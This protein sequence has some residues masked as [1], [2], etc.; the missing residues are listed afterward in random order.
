M[1]NIHEYHTLPSIGSINAINLQFYSLK[2]ADLLRQETEQTWGNYDLVVRTRLD[3]E[4]TK[5]INLI[6]LK[7]KLD[8]NPNLVFTPNNYK[9]Y[10]NEYGMCDAFAIT[11]SKN[12]SIYSDLINFIP[13]YY[14]QGLYPHPESLLN[15]HLIKNSLEL[16]E[17]LEINQSYSYEYVD[18]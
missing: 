3:R 5:E 10:Y 1:Y 9:H 6:E 14:Q 2:Q 15:Y 16:D 11:S 4:I 18:W 13:S 12:M 7:N 17:T 8:Y